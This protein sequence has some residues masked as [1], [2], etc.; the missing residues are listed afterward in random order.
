MYIILTIMGTNNYT[1]YFDGACRGNPGNGGAGIV[2]YNNG[3]KYHEIYK[4]LE[5]IITN[6]SA[7]YQALLI[8]MTYLRRNNI[9]TCTIFGDSNLIINQMIGHYRCK[10][11]N[12]QLY[13][14]E[15][16]KLHFPDFK[17][18]HVRRENNKEADSLANKA[19][20]L[21]GDGEKHF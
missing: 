11:E 3:I 7:E 15:C 20:N 5:G 19:L 21:N 6:N 13:Y 1:L 16:K 10:S 4:L 2:I 18:E 17:Y 8:G 14:V 9:T 12:L